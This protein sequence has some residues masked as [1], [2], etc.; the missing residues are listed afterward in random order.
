MTGRLCRVGILAAILSGSAI[1]GYPADDYFK[2]D[3]RDNVQYTVYIFENSMTGKR[4]EFITIRPGNS[5]FSAI[6]G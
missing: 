5:T 1:P 4:R 3:N 2:I 6:T